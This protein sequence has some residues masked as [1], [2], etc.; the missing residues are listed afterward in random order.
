MVTRHAWSPEL[1]GATFGHPGQRAF[2]VIRNWQPSETHDDSFVQNADVEIWDGSDYVAPTEGVFG[3]Q[4]LR[5]RVGVTKSVSEATV[6]Y[7]H[8]T[9]IGTIRFPRIDVS[10]EQGS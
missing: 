5:M 6:T 10:P 3:E 7:T 1:I 4:R 9:E 2:N 8:F